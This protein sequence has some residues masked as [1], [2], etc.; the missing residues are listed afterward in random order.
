MHLIYFFWL[1]L[2]SNVVKRD[3]FQNTN[4]QICAEKKNY[5]ESTL[6]IIFFIC[7]MTVPYCYISVIYAL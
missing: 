5:Y 2:Y 7:K 4:F 6:D 3:K 1:V